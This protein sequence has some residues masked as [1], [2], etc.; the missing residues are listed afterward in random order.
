MDGLVVTEAMRQKLKQY[1]GFDEAMRSDPVYKQ[2]Y[3]VIKDMYPH[4]PMAF[5]E[6]AMGFWLMTDD[7][8]VL[9][10][11]E[12]QKYLADAAERVYNMKVIKNVPED[13]HGGEA[14]QPHAAAEQCQQEIGVAS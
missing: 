2:V 14:A 7:E 6:A 11:E 9:D 8:S 13:E 5:L 12:N 10:S 3:A 4:Y 1:K